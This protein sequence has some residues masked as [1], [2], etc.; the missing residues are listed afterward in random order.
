[1]SGFSLTKNSSQIK[2]IITDFLISLKL[3]LIRL[4]RSKKYKL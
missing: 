4:I 3:E 2:Q 1:M